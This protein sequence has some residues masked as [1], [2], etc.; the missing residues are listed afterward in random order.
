MYPK[1]TDIHGHTSRTLTQ[2]VTQ[3]ATE[4]VLP[5][6]APTVLW[7]IK[8]SHKTQAQTAK[9]TP[10]LKLMDRRS[11]VQH[12]HNALQ[13]H[14]YTHICGYSKYRPGSSVC[15]VPLTP[16]QVPLPTHGSPLCC[17]VQLG[18]S[19]IH[20]ALTHSSHRHRMLVSPPDT[21][22]WTLHPLNIPASNHGP[23]VTSWSR[24]R[25]AS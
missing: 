6:T 17:L 3:A 16:S 19:G 1:S 25:F 22:A 14:K 7:L 2:L 11:L 21:P 18:A 24:L 8:N 23:L 10:S 12:T 9:S 15:L 13:I 4:K 5:S 20:T